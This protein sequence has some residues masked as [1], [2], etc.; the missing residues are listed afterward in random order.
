MTIDSGAKRK[1]WEE[2]IIRENLSVHSLSA[3]VY[4][5]QQPRPRG[6]AA[7]LPGPRRGLLYHYRMV[8]VDYT[9][10]AP[11]GIMLDCGFTNR[12]VPP[13][14]KGALVNKRVMRAQKENG[15]YHI[16][17]TDLTVERIFTYKAVIERVVDGDTLLANIDCGFGLWTKQYLRLKWID[18]PEIRNAGGLKAKQWME[19]ELSCCPFVIVQTHKSDQFDRYLADIYCLPKENDPHTVAASGRYLNQEILNKGFAGVWK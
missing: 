3:L 10:D 4:Q 8:K 9:N 11:G 5:S 6:K 18:A 14:C 15:A 12:I 19:R 16:V 17:Y 13:P 7:E 1:K 2:R